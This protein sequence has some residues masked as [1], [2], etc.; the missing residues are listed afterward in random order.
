MRCSREQGRAP[1]VF[2]RQ[3]GEDRCRSKT[4]AANNKKERHQ[5]ENRTVETKTRWVDGRLVRETSLGDGMKLTETFSL[6][7][8]G[9]RL[10]VGVKF[11]SSHLPR[12]LTL[13]RVYDDTS[14]R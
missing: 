10:H 3:T 6:A 7:R 11:E 2:I 4:F 12:P 5:F 9:E 14:T 1:H 8:E 13:E